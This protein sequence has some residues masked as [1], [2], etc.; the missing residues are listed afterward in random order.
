MIKIKNLRKTYKIDDDQTIKAL[1]GVDFSVNPGE[2]IVILGQSGSGKSTLL[3]IIGGIDR[4]TSGEALVGDRDISKKSSNELAEYRKKSVGTIFQTFN[5]I[6]DMSVLENVSLPLR[7]SGIKEKEQ[8][9][10][11]LEALEKVGLKE[12][13]TS[14]PSMLS[15]GQ[16]QR[17]AIARALINK[18]NVLLCDEPTG[19]LDSKTGQDIMKILQDLNKKGQTIIMVTHNQD[20]SSLADKVVTM[21]DGKI[22]KEKS[23]SKLTKTVQ[24]EPRNAKTISVFQ[25]LKLSLKNLKRMKL[26][27]FLT[28]FGVAIGAMAI[29]ILVSFGAGL[30]KGVNDQFEGLAQLEEIM[31]SGDKTMSQSGMNFSMTPSMEK[32]VIKPL[33]DKTIEE[34]KNISGVKDV[35]SSTNMSGDIVSGDKTGALFMQ[36]SSPLEF[37]SDPMKQKVKYGA[38]LKND[39][40]D[41][42]IIPYTLLEPLGYKNA[43]DILGKEVTLKNFSPISY[44]PFSQAPPVLEKKEYKFKV[45]GVLDEK[46]KLTAAVYVP[47]KKAEQM[48][49]E[50]KS[51]EA[52][53]DNPAIYDSLIVRANDVKVAKEIKKAIADKEYGAQSFDDMLKSISNV[54]TIMQSILGV[55]GGIALLV[56]SL[57]IVNTMLMSILERT[58]EIGIM[59]ALGAR[60]KDIRRIFLYEAMAI[61]LIGGVF[62]LILGYAGSKGLG[63]ILN[64]Y[65]SKGGGD[66]L[67]KFYIP[68]YLS[69]G[70]VVFSV[71]VASFAGYF[72][73]RR[74]SRL[75]PVKALKYE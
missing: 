63:A 27:V 57:G 30:Q 44:D 38:Y 61:G 40:D 20:F 50:L 8:K 14:T 36:S 34:F 13:A 59:K 53:K 75:D 66:T 64:N 73:A 16:Q 15:G 42:V 68:S 19:N 43:N 33:N 24:Y 10:L 47:N 7:L 46:E 72:P 29:V 48:I 56:A 45:V 21:L 69:I 25:S 6:N 17:V 58:R 28:S 39:N 54:F 70:V 26:R 67:L 60:I 62:G 12:R 5:L 65:L 55:V 51:E 9:R 23:N 32:K 11:A 41:T 1:D 31:V 49:K 71:L 52:K 2:F 22:I 74:A 18:P 4:P 3:N 37:V 35:Y